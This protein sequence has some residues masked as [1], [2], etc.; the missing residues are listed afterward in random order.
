MNRNM[1][2]TASLTTTLAL[3]LIGVPNA[4]DSA[5]AK[6][7]GDIVHF[8][9]DLAWSPDGTRIVFS[10]APISRSR[11]EKE[12]WAAFNNAHYDIEI[13]HADGTGRRR[14]TDSPGDDLG[15]AWSPDGK[16]IV[17]SSARDGDADLWMM[18]ADGGHV[19]RLLKREGKDSSPSWSPDGKRIVWAARDTEGRSRVHVMAA[20]G[21]GGKSLTDG[22]A[23][24]WSPVWSPDGARILFYSNHAGDGAD[25][26]MVMAADGTGARDVTEEGHSVYPGWSPDGQRILYSR[27]G[28]IEAIGADGE[29]P[30]RLRTHGFFARWSPDGRRLAWIAGTMP[31]TRI[32]VGPADD[33]EATNTI[34][35]TCPR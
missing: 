7:A 35:L 10:S 9:Q 15:A 24:A 34:C 30:T 26:V 2:R 18:D 1:I 5:P 25:R 13:V 33:T 29:N 17:F 4:H 6:D 23:D 20:D 31:D 16:R 28:H 27:D 8:Y 3:L 32:L 11:F 22:T 12:S 14:L 21:T 19:T